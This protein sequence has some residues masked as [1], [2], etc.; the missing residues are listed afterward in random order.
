MY[1]YV[2]GSGEDTVRVLELAP[3]GTL[4]EVQLIVDDAILELDNNFGEFT[5]ATAGGAEFLIVHGF[6]D[7]GIS[8][9]QIGN[10][11]Q[12]T[13]TFNVDDSAA[14]GLGLNGVYDTESV[15]IGNTTFVLATGDWRLRRCAHRF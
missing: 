12:L 7:D 15:Q 3:D 9:F 11:G 1:V 4:S 6:N 10:D 14:L 8:V 5:I 13:S 2:G